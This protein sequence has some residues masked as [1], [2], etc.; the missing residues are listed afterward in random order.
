MPSPSPSL[1]QLC[2][3][4]HP[5]GFLKND[6]HLNCSPDAMSKFDERQF[7]ND[8]YEAG[9]G[10]THSPDPF[11]I[12]AYDAFI[13]NEIPAPGRALDL[14]SGLGRHAIWLGERGWTV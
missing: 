3:R 11:L 6:R 9:H 14:A 8:R 12:W 1:L 13:R 2:Y 4:S 10:E 5:P 7:W